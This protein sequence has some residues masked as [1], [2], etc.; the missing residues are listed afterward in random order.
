MSLAGK[1]LKRFGA[2]YVVLAVGLAPTFY[3]WWH[4]KRVV[5]AREVERFDNAVQNAQ[6]ML[7]SNLKNYETA[8]R[9]IQSFFLLNN[10]TP[11][12][13]ERFVEVL[14]PR[15]N[16]PFLLNFGFVDG[17]EGRFP[18]R[19]MDE[20]PGEVSLLDRSDITRDPECRAALDKSRQNGVLASTPELLFTSGDGSPPRSAI[21]CFLPIYKIE[22]NRD[23]AM[24]RKEL[25]G[26]VFA[27]FDPAGFTALGHF[28]GT[29]KLVKVGVLH[30]AAQPW[31]TSFS[32]AFVQVIRVS[33]LGNEWKLACS[34]LPAFN[35]LSQTELPRWILYG[36]LSFSLML[37]WIALSQA[38]GRLAVERANAGLEKTSEALRESEARW[39]S[40]NKELETRVSARTAELSQSNRRLLGEITAR[41]LAE[42]E[43]RKALA[44]EKEL[45][46]L[47]SNFVSMV[48]HEFRTPL[49]IVMT[50]SDIL[51]RYLTQLPDGERAEHLQAIQKSVKRMSAL[52]EEVL[53]LGRVEAGK[54]Q[55]NPRP[56]DL[57]ELCRKIANEVAAGSH[58]KSVI[59][60]QCDPFDGPVNLD[61]T[62]LRPILTNLLS[63]AIKYSADGSTINLWVQRMVDK[64]SFRIAD[65]GIG[66]PAS[67]RE[68]L[69]T[70][71][72]RG[73]NTEHIAGTGLG[74]TIVKRCVDLHGGE[75]TVESVEGAGAE[76]K[77]DIPLK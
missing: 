21:V 28:E 40:L 46:Q 50:S 52:I 20:R 23:H 27:S 60:V 41:E 25:R 1:H 2:A 9:S 65:H 36:G 76:F 24:E 54:V 47:K 73:R 45:H 17:A 43:L 29:E 71:F 19:F 75:I 38:R 35:L 30:P 34:P 49:G 39:K 15:R 68:R 14:D 53:L 12:A 51:G 11:G 13:W 6:G 59:V 67:D 26:A 42:D 37:F 57:P 55:F 33:A 32:S 5:A 22:A 72:H 64:L 18:I 66:I 74:L 58:E 4:M 56:L 44:A 77:V 10:T 31:E 69:F 61:E 16:F 7:E 62:L 8:L 3:A 63:N 70:A 48:S